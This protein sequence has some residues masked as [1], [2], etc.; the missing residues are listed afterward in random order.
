MTTVKKNYASLQAVQEGNLIKDPVA[1]VDVKGIESLTKSSKSEYT[2]EALR[3][4]LVEDI[5]KAPAID[6][7]RFVKD[8]AILE[9]S[10]IN[11]VH[12]GEKKYFRPNVIKSINAYSEPI[13]I[14]GIK[15][16]I[17]FNTIK[18]A[19][20]Q[21]INLEERN[22]IDIA[23]VKINKA[24]IEKIKDDFPEIY[25]NCI[26]LLDMPEFKDGADA[27]SIPLETPTPEWLMPFIDYTEI[28]SSNLGSFPYSS[29]G[30]KSMEKSGVTY[31][32]IIQ[33]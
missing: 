32:N 22:A 27:I 13:R 20:M 1:A 5:L 28:I 11:S 21:G 6:Q 31:T 17:A 14:Q 33:L 7:I 16:A 25:E 2:R 29:I 26:K 9:R 15:G 8:I 24:T 12:K 10:I 23:K 18:P 30:L 4:I 19:D 3:K